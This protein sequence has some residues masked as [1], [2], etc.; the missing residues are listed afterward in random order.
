MAHAAAQVTT[1]AMTPRGLAATRASWR[2]RSTPPS[3]VPGRVPR[4]PHPFEKNQKF[5][6]VLAGAGTGTGTG[7]KHPEGKDV[8]LA[9]ELDALVAETRESGIGASLHVVAFSGGVD[10][11]LAA[12]LV[13]RAFGDGD[14]VGGG[15]AGDASGDVVGGAGA[16]GCVAAIG[17]SPALPAWQLAEVGL[18]KLKPVDR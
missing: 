3:A 8:A 5:G 1:M 2:R 7:T 12:Y 10:S 11:S 14:G 16:R 15:N 17:V 6:D 13:Q 9:A 18:Y 4:H